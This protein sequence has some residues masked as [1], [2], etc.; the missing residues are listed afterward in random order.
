[1][2]ES[3]NSEEIKRQYIRFHSGDM[4]IAFLGLEEKMFSIFDDETI[5]FKGNIAGLVVDES[6]R[7]CSLVILNK[8]KEKDFLKTG[9]KCIVKLGKESPLQAEVKWR[10]EL[11]RNIIRVGLE[12][13]DFEIY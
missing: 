11:D 7:G 1:M 10:Q 13:F 8:K 12:V 6:Y 4:D 9:T 2:S 3:K 5:E